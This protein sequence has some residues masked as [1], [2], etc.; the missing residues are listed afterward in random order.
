MTLP[1]AS[2]DIA[3]ANPAHDWLGQ[4]V[5]LG[6]SDLHL[7]VGHPPTLRRHGGLERL[8]APLLT[9][10]VMC[11]CLIPLCPPKA[12]RRFQRHRNVDFALQLELAGRVHRIC[13]NYFVSG[14]SLARVFASSP[15]RF[16]DLIGPGFP[17]NWPIN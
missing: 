7:V 11:A 6:A 2:R 3:A 17:R 9:D 5:A 14:R 15:A 16:R 4:A 12:F 10:E 8:S 13:A 1:E